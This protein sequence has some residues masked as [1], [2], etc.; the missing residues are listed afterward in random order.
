MNHHQT[1]AKTYI[2]QGAPILNQSAETGA[3]ESSNTTRVSSRSS[4]RYGP[5]R[6]A[7]VDV[8]IGLTDHRIHDLGALP[9]RWSYLS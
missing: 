3:V 9:L 6:Y 7:V 4:L 2:M 1:E 5:L 8:E